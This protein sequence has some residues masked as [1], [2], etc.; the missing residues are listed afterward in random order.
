MTNLS[1]AGL[2]GYF[3]NTSRPSYNFQMSTPLP[4]ARPYN[5]CLTPAAGQLHGPPP[6]P[7]PPMVSSQ[8]SSQ[9]TQSAHSSTSNSLSAIVN[10]APIYTS[11]VG[12]RRSSEPR[13]A[14]MTAHMDHI[15]TSEKERAGQVAQKS[16]SLN[17]F[18]LTAGQR[19]EAFNIISGFWFS[20]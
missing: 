14:T 13:L 11:E 10:N 9:S 6:I 16:W 17:T 18:G 19:T 7:P 2:P 5:P 15:Q 3:P 1:P 8:N 12:W 20:G 4:N